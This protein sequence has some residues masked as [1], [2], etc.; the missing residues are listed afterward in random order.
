MFSSTLGM[1]IKTIYNW[2]NESKEDTRDDNEI[3]E[4]ERTPLEDEPKTS[5][6]VYLTQLPKVESHYC[7]S[8]TKKQYLESVFESKTQLYREY[9]P[10][11]KEIVHTTKLGS[12]NFL[13]V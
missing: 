6:R 11:V 7:R 9:Q 10:G 5:A 3:D 1:N 13:K 2:L 12:L 4:N 8:K